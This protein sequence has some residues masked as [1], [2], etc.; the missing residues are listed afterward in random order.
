MYFLLFLHE[1]IVLGDTTESQFVH[2]IYLMRII[3][4]AVHEGFD[5]HGECRGE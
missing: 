5:S 4:I 2:Q 1:G 3:Q